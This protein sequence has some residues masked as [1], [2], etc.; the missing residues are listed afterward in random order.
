MEQRTTCTVPLE[1]QVHSRNSCLWKEFNS[2]PP[3]YHTSIREDSWNVLA[4]NSTEG[5]GPM[6]GWMLVKEGAG[7]D[8]WTMMDSFYGASFMV[9]KKN[10]K[11]VYLSTRKVSDSD[12]SSTVPSL[13]ALKDSL[14]VLDLHKSR[15]LRELDASICNLC[16][17]LISLPDSIGNLSNLTE[18]R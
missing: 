5:M 10:G 11:V 8:E 16:T 6:E 1:K 2:C 15:Y 7:P 3:N 9:C 17:N 13:E 18:V 12:R 14:L 4:L